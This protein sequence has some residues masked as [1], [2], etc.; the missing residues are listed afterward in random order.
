[1]AISKVIYDGRTLIDLTSDTVDAAH[2]LKDYTAHGADGTSV[3]GTC[4][5]DSDTTD[6]NATAAMILAGTAQ[7]PNTA[8]VNGTKVTGTMPNR[9]GNNITISSLTD[10]TI[11]SGFYDGSGSAGISSTEKAKIVATNI[12]EGVEILGVTGS[13]SSEEGVVAQSV[14]VTPSSSVQTI[15]PDSSQGYNYISQVT[16]AAIPY[17]ETPNAA[18]GIT[19]TIG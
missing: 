11:P 9:G 7:A 3:T 14:S 13:M 18:N 12:R 16:V 5:Y 8:Y 19:V 4:T 2:L 10:V 6:A 17:V 15:V 1:M